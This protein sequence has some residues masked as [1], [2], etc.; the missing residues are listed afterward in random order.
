VF[1]PVFG[2]FALL[3]DAESES[4][5]KLRAAPGL[6]GDDLAEDLLLSMRA[7]EV[8]ILV[9]HGLRRGE[10]LRLGED[11]EMKV[12]CAAGRGGDFAPGIFENPTDEAA[13]GL[14]V[15]PV[16][17]HSDAEEAEVLEKSI[18]LVAQ[19]TPGAEEVAF[20]HAVLLKHKRRLRLH[21]GVVGGEVVGEEL[22]V[23]ENLID[24][25]AEK[26]RF[27]TKPPH[28]CTVAGLVIANDGI[29]RMGHRRTSYA[30]A[31]AQRRKLRSLQVPACRAGWRH[32]PEKQKRPPCQ[33]VFFCWG[34]GECVQGASVVVLGLFLH[35]TR[36][37]WRGP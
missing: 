11:I 17:E 25:L 5:E 37:R 31:P 13:R 2:D 35:G 22:A 9:R 16:A 23:L 26:T 32:S 8:E 7:E 30:G 21:I 28:R 27:A 12:R 36:R 24:R 10:F 6:E 1:V 33:V 3:D 18:P 34:G 4:L 19:R 20:D 29:R 15:A 14:I